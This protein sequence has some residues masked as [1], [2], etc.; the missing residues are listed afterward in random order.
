GFAYCFA[1]GESY[2]AESDRAWTCA[3]RSM[4]QLSDLLDRPSSTA[5]PPAEEV[6][7]LASELEDHLAVLRRPFTP[8]Q[9]QPFIDRVKDA[10]PSEY[11]AMADLLTSP[12]LAG[13]DRLKLFEAK[14]GL[15][16]YLLVQT[17]GEEEKER[18]DKVKTIAA[19][20]SDRQAASQDTVAPSRRG[21]RALDLM[22]LSGEPGLEN[23]DHAWQQVQADS[24]EAAWAAFGGTLRE[25][26]IDRIPTNYRAERNPAVKER[27]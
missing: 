15:G 16:Q 23:V 8:S 25:M 24:S 17:L 21:R 14:R 19:A 1:G 7:R 26:L 10:G 6:R 12:R 3:V 27:L 11:L 4:Q 5:A 2:A 20:G 22:R 13:G 18:R 9:W